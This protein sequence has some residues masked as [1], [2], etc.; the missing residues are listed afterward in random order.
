MRRPGW[1]ARLADAVDLETLRKRW[2]GTAE[3]WFPLALAALLFAVLYGLA[4]L[5]Q[6]KPIGGY[7]IAYFRQA[8]WLVGH[9]KPPFVTLRGIHLL[10]KAPDAAEGVTA[11]LEKRQAR[12]PMQVST[13]LPD[14]GPRWPEPPD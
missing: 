9:G 7:D 6:H 3:R 8:A 14:L 4:M 2:S 12:F 11:F 13:D 5:R 1:R 10:G